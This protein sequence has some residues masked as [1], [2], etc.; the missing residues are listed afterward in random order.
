MG[1]DNMERILP[2]SCTLVLIAIAFFIT[3][4]SWAQSNRAV[5]V[6]SENA[7]QNLAKPWEVGRAS[8][9][10]LTRRSLARV[11]AG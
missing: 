5:A 2:I 6:Q 3:R 10:F 1:K 8:H 4:S 11:V 7:A 9:A